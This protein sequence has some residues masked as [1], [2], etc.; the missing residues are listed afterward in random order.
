MMDR[1]LRRSGTRSPR[2]RGHLLPVRHVLAA[3]GR[4]RRL[5]ALALFVLASIPVLITSCG[6]RATEPTVPEPPSVLP[7]Q[8]VATYP[9]QRSTFVRYDTPTFWVRFA[10]PLDTTS[11]STMT[12]YLKLD[13]ARQPIRV[14]WAADSNTIVITPLEALGL[15]KTYT[16]ELSPDLA[17]REHVRLGRKFWWQFTIN[18]LYEPGGPSPA[19]D[20]RGESPFVALGWRNDANVI[21]GGVGYD[22]YV[23]T[24]SAAVAARTVPRLARVNGAL[25]SPVHRWVEDA[26]NYWALTAVNYTTGERLEGPVWRYDVL[27][28]R[29][30]RVDSLVI[31]AYQWGSLPITVRLRSGCTN[32][33][34]ITGPD[35]KCG[36]AWEVYGLSQR[37]AEAR[38]VLGTTTEYAAALPTDVSLWASL[39]TFGACTFWGSSS[40]LVDS[41]RGRLATAT[42]PAPRVVSFST[43]TL[44]SYVEAMIRRGEL[45][46]FF[47][48]RSAVPLHY[49]PPPGAERAYQPALVLRYYMPKQ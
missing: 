28:P 49:V 29:S 44:T 3:I 34:L 20:T 17:T 36:I 23:G 26:A 46:G 8:V 40:P 22:L 15:L 39:Q 32:E 30:A 12:V 45:A 7:P 47:M 31:E 27:G 10:A 9:P 14:R 33:D 38:F 21:A 1:I 37:L 18:S 11:V 35:Y 4:G 19:T 48:F 25:Y 41:N 43:D 6:R 16:V 2:G 13:D 42:F 5:L 24:D